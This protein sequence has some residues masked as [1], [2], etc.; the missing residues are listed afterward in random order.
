ME[1]HLGHATYCQNLRQFIDRSDSLEA[2]WIPVTYA[3]QGGLWEQIPGL[4]ASLRGAVRGRAQV[5]Q[6]LAQTSSD[7]VFFNTQVPAALAGRML[8]RQPYVVAT[9]LTPL[10]YDQLSRLYG[11][12]P[13][14]DGPLTRYKRHVNTVMLRGAARLL[15]WSSWARDSLIN[16]YG[17]DPARIEVLPPGVDLQTWTPRRTRRAG[18]F[19]ILFVGG[20]FQRKGG[21]L[22]LRAFRALPRGSAELA[23]VTRSLIA[24]E[25][26]V[27]IHNNMQPNSPELIALFQSCDAF[28]LPTEAE[29]FG[30]AAVEASAA[31]LP[32]IATAIGGLRDV[33]IDGETGFLLQPGDMQGVSE[34]LRL[35]AQDV[36]R[37]W[38]MG[39]AARRYTESRFDARQIAQ[40]VVTTLLDVEVR[41]AAV[42]A[43]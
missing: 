30:I 16:D 32:V 8:Q 7:V 33:V 14:R 10:Q 42:Q 36:D 26:G 29:A 24:Q 25:D 31:G 22:L 6:G 15:P 18:P 34:R 43:Y 35:L 11:H 39:Q 21:D 23:V 3:A 2:R 28:V 41:A 1:Q 37:C 13:D 27:T 9:D 12:T 19:R 38:R 17:V 40:R 5:R 4:P 20:D